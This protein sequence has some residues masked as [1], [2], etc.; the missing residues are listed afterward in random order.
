MNTLIND[1]IYVMSYIYD[2]EYMLLHIYHK[3]ICIIANII[4]YISYDIYN[5][6]HL[7]IIYTYM[8]ILV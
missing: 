7:Y 5:I 4:C 6:Y 1:I 3:L 2:I 8:C